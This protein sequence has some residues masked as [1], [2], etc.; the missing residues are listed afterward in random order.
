MNAAATIVT[1]SEWY[2]CRTQHSEKYGLR[3]FYI[4]I[5]YINVF[6]VQQ[7][8]QIRLPHSPCRSF[9]QGVIY[10]LKKYV[11][12]ACV[13][14]SLCMRVCVQMSVVLLYTRT[15]AK[16]QEPSKTQPFVHYSRIK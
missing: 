11:H 5:I 4:T 2:G 8:Y 6:S 14:V 13:C 10:L 3:V 1:E 15:Y 9:S 16:S 7:R 12:H